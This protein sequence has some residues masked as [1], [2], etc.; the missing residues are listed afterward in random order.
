MNEVRRNAP[1]ALAPVETRLVTVLSWNLLHGEG[2]T[3]SDVVR[4]LRLFAPDILLMQEATEQ[5]DTLPGLLGGDYLRTPLPGRRHGV[6]SWSRDGFAGTPLVL[7]LPAGAIVR[8]VCHLV[9]L[10]G[11][12]L[13][14]VHLSHGQVLNRRQL[15]AVSECLPAHA[16]ILGDF[17]LVGP[18]LLPHFRDVGP[19]SPTHRMGEMLPLR[20]DRCLVRGL[21][22][23][24]AFRLPRVRSDHHPILVRLRMPQG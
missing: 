13:A 16:A 20:I 1:G 3:V 10:H 4:L 19:R 7:A 17:N 11:C 12:S 8:R 21:A 9:P 24:A 18:V 6:A 22:C 15:R 2:A 5:I 23:E 14:N